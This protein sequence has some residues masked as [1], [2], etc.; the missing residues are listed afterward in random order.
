MTCVYLAMQPV[1]VKLHTQYALM[2]N[3][4]FYIIEIPIKS[5]CI[6]EPT[7]T[8]KSCPSG[9][10]CTGEEYICYLEADG[11]SGVCQTEDKIPNEELTT[12]STVDSTSSDLVGENCNV[13]LSGNASCHSET[14]YSICLN[15]EYESSNK[16]LDTL[17]SF[18]MLR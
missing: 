14:T 13:C 12:S 3:I 17:A 10:V 16:K 2:V 4:K 1:T 18:S 9:Y 5:V 11:Y 7:W 6:G 8:N 15:G